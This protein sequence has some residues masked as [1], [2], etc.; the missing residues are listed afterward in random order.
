MKKQ[1]KIQINLKE[2]ISLIVILFMII[3]STGCGSLISGISASKDTSSASSTPVNS[4]EET[5]TTTEV[6]PD[7]TA[8]IAE[9]SESST[10]ADTEPETTSTAVEVNDNPNSE[11]IKDTGN[12]N[13]IST[14]RYYF[15]L[16]IT[17]FEE[18]KYVEAQYYLEK[19]K[20]VYLIMADYI[21]FYTAKSMLMQKKYDLAAES[22]KNLINN[23]PQSIFGERA[24]I[25][26]ADSYF[27]QEDF[28]NAEAQ[29]K[30]FCGKFTS[31]ELTSYA[32]FQEGVCS[33]KSGSGETAYAIY[34]K[35]YIE[36][37]ASEYA[38]LSLDNLARLSQEK[39]LPVFEPTIDEL[40]LRAQNLFSIYYYDSAL[41]DLNK[42]TESEG[43]AAKYPDSYSKALFK[44][45]MA[46][47]N[48]NNYGNAR[49]YLELYYEKFP[50]GTFADD[51]LYY[52]GRSL[53]NLNAYNEAINTY[54]KML[55]K[56]PQSNFG[57]DSLYRCGRIAYI[58]DDWQNAAFYF[59]RLIDEYPEGDM[60]PT[61]YWELGWIQYRLEEFD[62]A[63]ITFEKMAGKF[64][65]GAL[66][67]KG[68][69]WQAKCFLKSGRE[70]EAMSLLEKTFTMEPLSYYGFA[71]AEILKNAGTAVAM[72]VFN[73]N[74]NPLNPGIAEIIPDIY[75]GMIPGQITDIKNATHINKAKELLFIKFYDSAAAEIAA[76]KEETDADPDK[77]LE[78]STL[79]FSSKDYENSIGIVQKNASK[80]SSNLQGDKRDYYYYLFFPY[81]Y[82]DLILKYSAQ[83][84]IEP[85]FILA[86]I[87]EESR[88][89]ADAGSHA[90][91][92]GLMQIMPA[93]GKSIASQIGISNFN[94]SMLHDPQTSITMGSFYISQMLSNFGNNKYYALGA[95]NGGPG[96][97]QKWISKYGSLDIDEFIESLTYDETKNYIKKVMASYFIYN[98]LYK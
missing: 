52:L 12:I 33:E 70:A 19:I 97:M 60:L 24:L 5:T 66:E 30:L 4:D 88:F 65:G 69:F 84:N 49:K 76:S 2:I 43:V 9:T 93:T 47:F 27:L 21:S 6:P 14:Q 42:I 83:Y 89:K 40:Y 91:A 35:I 32:L 54:K 7:T 18:K 13:D 87:R 95:Y 75:S 41:K 39:S 51:S 62:S 46:Y 15:Q 94:E 17:S 3:A 38:Q 79:Y 20:S 77:I 63:A 74:L 8:V 28:V 61:G 72:P 85:N 1:N 82:N 53:T 45:G 23:Y 73:L 92:Q 11:E 98:L 37:P 26:L 57:D 80:L 58:A 78:I 90:G 25:E 44:T 48:I 86:I 56:F 64:A 22:Y 31:S 10:T 81:A 16:G 96:A 71:S 50:S 59:Q 68:L 67:E 36:Y 34:K 29:Y 55:E